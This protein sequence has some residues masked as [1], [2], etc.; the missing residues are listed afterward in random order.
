MVPSVQGQI[1][2]FF[3]IILRCMLLCKVTEKA[4]CSSL[5]WSEVLHI[6]CKTRVI[7][8]MTVFLCSRIFFILLICLYNRCDMIHVM[9][10]DNAWSCQR[11]DVS[12]ALRNTDRIMSAI[13]CTESELRTSISS[14]ERKNRYF[15]LTVRLKRPAWLCAAI[16]GRSVLRNWMLQLW[17]SDSGIGHSILYCWV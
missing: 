15:R 5:F 17:F 14:C 1:F 3:S 13:N 4:V 12:S 2:H 6:A 7:R 8:I 11:Q 10:H 9:M 16:L